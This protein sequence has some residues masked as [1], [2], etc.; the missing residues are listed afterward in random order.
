[1]ISISINRRTVSVE[2]EE[3]P[4]EDQFNFA[5]RTLQAFT[6]SLPVR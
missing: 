6:E 2:S 4:E 5:I 1:M 3:P